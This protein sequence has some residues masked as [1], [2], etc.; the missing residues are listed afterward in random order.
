MI[1]MRATATSSILYL[2]AP[3]YL[4]QFIQA[5]NVKSSIATAQN[6]SDFESQLRLQLADLHYPLLNFL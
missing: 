3:G 6:L 4:L 2:I 1:E 5:L